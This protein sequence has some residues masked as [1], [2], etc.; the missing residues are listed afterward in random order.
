MEVDGLLTKRWGPFVVVI[1]VM[2]CASA[3]GRIIYVDDDAAGA[4]DG[5]SWKDAYVYLQDAQA[6][7]NEAEKPVEIRIG[8]GTYRP[9][10]GA[11]QTKGDR[12]SSFRLI[13]GVALRGGFAGLNQPDSDARDVH[14]YATILSGDLAGDDVDLQD[15]RRLLEEPTRAENAYH[16]VRSDN[17]DE[18]A[19]L[20][21]VIVTSGNADAADSDNWRDAWGG[22]LYHVDGS[23][24]L[25]DCTFAGNTARHGGGL[26]IETSSGDRASRPV[27]T[28]C[29][30]G[31]NA[32]QSFGGAVSSGGDDGPCS[33]LMEDCAFVGNY[34]GQNGGGLWIDSWD[35][36]DIP[37]QFFRCTFENNVAE[38]KGA[39]LYL[40]DSG[41]ITLQECAFV[42]NGAS[43]GA[44]IYSRACDYVAQNCL[45]TGNSA[46]VGDSL[47][48]GSMEDGPSD[49]VLVN[50]ILWEAGDTIAVADDSTLTIAYSDVSGGWPGPGNID[51]DPLFADPGYWDP[52]DTPDDPNDDFWIEGDFHLMSQAGRWHPLNKGW[53]LDNVTSPCIDAGD[54]GSLVAL[55]PYPHGGRINMGAYGGGS[56]ASKSPSDPSGKYGG[57]S[58]TAEDPYRIYAPEHM[59][60]MSL[61]SDDWSRHFQLVADVDMSP[62]PG[63]DWRCIGDGETAFRGRFD[64]AGHS[65]LNFACLSGAS[66]D[67]GLFG[68]VR[69]TTT[70]ICNL[71]LVAP[72]VECQSGFHVAALVGRL[73][74]GSIRNCH[75]QD[76]QVR[77]DT[78]VGGLVGWN[79]G[80]VAMCSA[81]GTV[82]G[83]YT[84]GGLAGSVSWH[85]ETLDCH[86]DAQV[87]GTNRLGGLAGA[88]WL[89]EVHRCS[90]AGEVK[91]QSYIGGLIGI[92][93]GGVIDDSYSIASVN[94]Y[95]SV[96]G[97]AGRNAH[98]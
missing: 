12:N 68:H 10:E 14:A 2:L 61:H 3:C 52:N 62:L 26:Y 4:N 21:G 20:D 85:A 38:G 28:R 55:E 73:G 84:V 9:N 23:P 13:N 27:L 8:Q 51:A 71:Q 1:A 95:A 36:P 50:C 58:G 41:G 32:A 18:T 81:G 65:I 6:D 57:G 34:A 76:A 74:S 97:L 56:E 86:A 70:E 98:S 37:G 63:A 90:S 92:S 80:T 67:V 22:G 46:A 31:A 82:S 39:A 5:T 29:T 48:F 66:E 77:G 83:R 53:V 40:G 25:I 96:G 54:P 49:A 89:A 17:V 59:R 72:Q 64:G 88:C 47:A 44:G 91:G 30:F 43:T 16:V 15:A 7:A 75:V 33:A 93:E 24:A 94:G 19:V 11:G 69:G 79:Q 60:Q 87:T 42:G 78:F 45:F 35:Y